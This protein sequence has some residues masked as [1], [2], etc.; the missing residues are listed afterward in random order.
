MGGSFGAAKVANR[1][2]SGDTSRGMLVRLTDDVL[3]LNPSCVVMLMG[4]ND[5]EE[6]AEP[7]TIASDA[8]SRH[9]PEASAV[10]AQSHHPLPPAF[11]RAHVLVN[12]QRIRNSATFSAMAWR[13][14]VCFSGGSFSGSARISRVSRDLESLASS[15]ATSRVTSA[16][17]L[18]GSVSQG[19][20]RRV[21]RA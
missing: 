5:L 9:E 21:R 13:S 18:A 14:T 12:R 3:A 17:R 15:S 16:V 19:L 20:C 1:G 7:A 4:T 2:I 10:G 6:K 8:G 11:G